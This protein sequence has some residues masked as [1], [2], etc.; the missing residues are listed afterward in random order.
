QNFDEATIDYDALEWDWMISSSNYAT[1]RDD[2]LKAG[3]WLTSFAKK[4]AFTKPI[5]AP[6]GTLAQYTLAATGMVYQRLDDLYFAQAASD[7][8]QPECAITGGILDDSRLVVESCAAT[9]C[10]STI[11]QQSLACGGWTDIS[12]ALVG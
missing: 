7:D 9:G 12:A 1:V 10:G 5:Q 4:N 6:D 8:G 2:V 11:D 3:G